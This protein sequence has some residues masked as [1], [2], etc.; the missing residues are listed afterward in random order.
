MN[1]FPIILDSNCQKWEKPSKFDNVLEPSLP[2]REL[3]TVVALDHSDCRRPA[4]TNPWKVA[5]GFGRQARVDVLRTWGRGREG[6]VQCSYHVQ[7]FV[8]CLHIR[9]ASYSHTGLERAVHT[10]HHCDDA[11][12]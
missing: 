4:A 1:G 2:R 11:A 10:A 3:H 12:A 5:T 6:G 9:L 7:P 8:H